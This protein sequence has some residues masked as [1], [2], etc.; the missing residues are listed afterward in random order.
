MK[1]F[2]LYL[3]TINPKLYDNSKKE[4]VWKNNP[5]FWTVQC[6]SIHQ[7]S[8]SNNVVPSISKDKY[9]SI[10]QTPPLKWNFEK[11]EYCG[12]RNNLL[13]IFTFIPDSNKVSDYSIFLVNTDCDVI[14]RNGNIINGY[15]LQLKAE[16]MGRF[17]YLELWLDANVN[18]DKKESFAIVSE[19]SD[20]SHIHVLIIAI[21]IIMTII[22]ITCLIYV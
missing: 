18:N 19:K 4:W 15:D 7:T 9:V 11:N 20:S 21:I 16:Q 12:E 10:S 22:L 1:D 17:P 8:V 6:V 2:D 13:V 14:F 5:L 3:S